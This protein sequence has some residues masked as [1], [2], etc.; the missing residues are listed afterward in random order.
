LN[1]RMLSR[2]ISGLVSSFPLPVLVLMLVVMLIVFV[3]MASR[4]RAM[5]KGNSTPIEIAGMLLVLVFFLLVAVLLG[6][7]AFNTS[8]MP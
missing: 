8:I 1:I 4:I 7:A 5:F 2:D 6:R 3:G